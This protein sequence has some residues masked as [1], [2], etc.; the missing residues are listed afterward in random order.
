MGPG[1]PIHAP[2]GLGVRGLIKLVY[3]LLVD[4]QEDRTIP[5]TVSD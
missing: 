4:V 1:L 5:K 2:A 3:S